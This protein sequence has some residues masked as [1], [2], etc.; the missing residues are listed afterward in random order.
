MSD[1]VLELAAS[2]ERLVAAVNRE[3]AALAA[4]RGDV[5]ATDLLALSHLRRR[6]SLSPGAL[7]RALLMSP[8]GTT[9]VLR[10]LVAAGLAVRSA[11]AGNHRDV[12]V[13][14]TRDG[15]E[16]GAIAVEAKTLEGGSIDMVAL[17]DAIAMAV[18]QRTDELVQEEREAAVADTG[19]PTVVRWG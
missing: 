9:G 3:R 17:I 4:L 15:V 11:G 1:L 7:A 12:R 10:R 6:A 18:E 14:A 2:L 13:S 5:T 19:V 8:S 16:L